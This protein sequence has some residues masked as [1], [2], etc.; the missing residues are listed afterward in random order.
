MADEVKRLTAIRNRRRGKAFQSKV[1]KMTNGEN[2]GTLGGEDV[3]HHTY[4][5]EAK[6]FKS[7][8]G[9]SVMR[10]AEANCP[11]KKIPIAIIHINGQRHNKDLVQMRFEDWD[12]LANPKSINKLRKKV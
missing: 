9:E 3:R 7:Y 1:G 12:N 5:I 6:S 8:R 4:S 10:Q 11:E 2:I